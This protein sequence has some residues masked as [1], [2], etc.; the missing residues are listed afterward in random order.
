MSQ[1]TYPVCGRD[2]DDLQGGI[3]DDVK[4][5]HVRLW[6]IAI[7]L[8]APGVNNKLRRDLTIRTLQI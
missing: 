8:C 3:V 6:T 5:L 4:T 7:F 1:S 2:D